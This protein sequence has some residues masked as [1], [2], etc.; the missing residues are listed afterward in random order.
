M[1]NCHEVKTHIDNFA[2]LNEQQ[3]REVLAHTVDCE[4]CAKYQ[5]VADSTADLLGSFKN[6]LKQLPVNCNLLNNNLYQKTK[7]RA[8]KDQRTTLVGVT[9]MVVSLFALV[10]FYAQGDMALE[11]ALILGA[12]AIGGG[13]VAWWSARK[14]SRF[15]SVSSDPSEDFIQSWVKDLGRE[16]TITKVVAGLLSIEIFAV[17]F[18]LVSDSSAPEGLLVLLGVEAVLAIGVIYAF[19]VELPKL[20]NEL[21]LITQDT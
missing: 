9:S 16:I 18:K 15:S 1:K 5:V 4:Q 11:G 10:W 13:I 8:A 6:A 21:A 3:C 12:W 20:K 17:L 2:N 19:A 7:A 14:A